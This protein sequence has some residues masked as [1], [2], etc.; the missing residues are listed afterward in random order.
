[1]SDNDSDNEDQGGIN[2]TGFLF[3]NVDE[4]GELENDFFDDEAKKQLSSLHRYARVN[5]PK[6]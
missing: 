4:K 6:Q 1:M 2:L 3:G 5:D